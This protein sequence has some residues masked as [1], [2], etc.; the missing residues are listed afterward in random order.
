MKI[1]TTHDTAKHGYT[2]VT[3]PRLIADGSS[4]LS[5]AAWKRGEIEPVEAPEL[6]DESADPDEAKTPRWHTREAAEKAMRETVSK[7]SDSG[8]EAYAGLS[9]RDAYGAIYDHNSLGYFAAQDGIY[10]VSEWQD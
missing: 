5:L 10:S 3:T 7:L 2:I 9:V 8:P 6:I 4:P 1:E